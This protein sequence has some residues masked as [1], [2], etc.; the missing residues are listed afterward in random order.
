[1]P[2]RFKRSKLRRRIKRKRFGRKSRRS[3]AS[4]PSTSVMRGPSGFPDRIKI[5]LKYADTLTYTV[6]SGVA[7]YNQWRGNSLFD[8]DYTG[9]GHQPYGY[10]QWTAFYSQYRVYGSSIK[11]QPIIEGSGSSGAI[12]CWTAA[13]PSVSSTLPSY[14]YPLE[15]TPYCRT[16]YFNYYNTL[17]LSTHYMSTAK[18]YGQSRKVID[19][20]DNYASTTASNPNNGWFWTVVGGTADESTSSSF[21]MNVILT[22]YVEFYS[23]KY[24]S[25]S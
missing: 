20:E 19:A 7:V 13:W 16:K 1:M 12:S 3:G 4:R 11:V 25:S 21:R 8:P 17:K 2:K 23:R 6:T 18:I 24:I 5:K 9:T 15:E 14:P 22:Y 10:D